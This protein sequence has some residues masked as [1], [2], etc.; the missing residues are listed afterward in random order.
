MKKFIL[1][2][3]SLIIL[4]IFICSVLGL[5]TNRNLLS[6]ITSQIAQNEFIEPQLPK[7]I[8]F[9]SLKA[10]APTKS[11]IDTNLIEDGTNLSSAIESNSSIN[12]MA[13]EITKND[14]TNI[15]KVQSIYQWIAYNITYDKKEDTALSNGSSL[16]TGEIS[17]IN[18]FENKKSVCAGFAELFYTMMVHENI[19]V[20]LISGKGYSGTAWGSHMWNQVYISSLNAWVNIDTTFASSF[21]STEKQNNIPQDPYGI[22]INKSAIYYSKNGTEWNIGSADYFGS[23]NFSNSHKDGQILAQS[24]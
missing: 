5:N 6:S 2:L 24:S 12:N 22:F 20:R 9:Y 14:K 19:P 21:A 16:P 11:W 3:I 4:I 10:P 1:I 17:A 23:K 8:T 7:S 13:T 18:T 15:E